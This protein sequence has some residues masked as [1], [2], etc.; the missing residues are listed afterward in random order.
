[1]ASTQGHKVGERQAKKNQQTQYKQTDIE[2]NCEKPSGKP[3][4]AAKLICC[5]F[6]AT[7]TKTIK[8]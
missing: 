6:Y 3:P 5:Q 2:Q 1:L 4:T 7:K 8:Q